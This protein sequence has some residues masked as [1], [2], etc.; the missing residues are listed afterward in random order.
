MAGGERSVDELL[1]AAGLDPGDGVQI[2][3]GGRLAA[4]PFDPGLPLIV[5][6]APSAESGALAS[7]PGRHAREGPIAVLAA[8]YP[9]AHRLRPLPSGSPSRLETL[10]D[11]TLI[12]SD[13]LVPPL[14]AVDNLASPHGMAAISARL[15]APDGCPWDRRQDHRSL[16]PYLLEEAYETL[17]AIEHG[18]PADLAEELGDLYLQVILHAQFAAEAGEFDLT[19]VYRG[20]G[21]KI[22]RRHPHVFGEVAVRDVDQVVAN[23]ESI[24]SSER[25]D[26]GKPRASFADVARTLPALPASREIQERASSLGWDWPTV[27]GVWEKVGEELDELRAAAAA[28]SVPE[29]R[30][31]ELGDVLFALANLARWLGID[32]EEALR[33]ANRRWVDRYAAVEALAAERGLV[34]ADLQSA[35]KDELWNE[36]KGR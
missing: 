17:D 16:R 1:A 11:A 29:E 31:H 5:L 32:P 9:S 25:E 12:A 4:I 24:K 2:V 33:S 36:V 34:L 28:P 21:T 23:W 19:D 35:A 14:A 13:W 3:S 20:L 26:A 27:D 6:A 10:D 18:T 22:I 15:R 30:L 8:L 7:L